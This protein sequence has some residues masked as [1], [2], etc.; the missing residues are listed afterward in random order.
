MIATNKFVKGSSWQY[1]EFCRVG[2]SKSKGDM[3]S[4]LFA[5]AMKECGHSSDLMVVNR[6]DN[7]KYSIQCK[8][9]KR[10]V[11]M[12]GRSCSFFLQF[13][14]KDEKSAKCTFADLNHSCKSHKE[15]SIGADHSSSGSDGEEH[16]EV[17]KSSKSIN[18]ATLQE[19]PHGR[20]RNPPIKV[21]KYCDPLLANMAFGKHKEGASMSAKTLVQSVSNSTSFINMGERQASR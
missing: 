11:A 10:R 15:V 18:M 2:A 9:D 1:P 20:E 12:E 6:S 21:L 5:E 19:A 8:M 16:Y 4:F 14:L 3:K 13:A 17:L 7:K